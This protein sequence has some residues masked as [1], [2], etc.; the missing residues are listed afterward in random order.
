MVALNPDFRSAD[1][2]IKPANP[3]FGWNGT[4]DD[5]QRSLDLLAADMPCFFNAPVTPKIH[6]S[7]L[8]NWNKFQEDKGRSPGSYDWTLLDEWIHGSP[9]YWL[10]Q[11]IGSCVMSNTFRPWVAR[12]MYQIGMLGLPE[13]Y[14]GRNEFGTNNYS[15]YGPWSYGMAR[16]RAKMRGGDGLYC[17]PMLESLMKDGVVMCNTPKLLTILQ[18]RGLAGERDFPE[19]QGNDG[20]KL[21]R[22]FGNWKYLDELVPYANQRVLNGSICKSGDELFEA[23]YRGETAFICSGLAIKKDTVHRDGFTIH[24]EN[25]RDSWSHNTYGGGTMMASDN[26]EFLRHGNESWGPQHMYNIR[27]SEVSEWFRRGKVTVALIKSIEGIGSKPA[28][29]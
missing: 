21:Y 10:P 16:R 13:E 20:A 4:H 3:L 6:P 11:I 5:E 14:M 19:P 29:A 22:D 7:I 18:A 27:R 26:Q 12:A 1:E 9:L 24:T 2:V 15:F 17:A 23:L 28:V 25:T 8:A